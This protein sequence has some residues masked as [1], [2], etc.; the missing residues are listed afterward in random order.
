[1]SRHYT[2]AE[3]AQKAALIREHFDSCALTTDVI[4]GFPGE[5]DEEFEESLSFVKR[6]AFSH[7]HVFKYS[8]RE[9]TLA[10]RMPDQ[11]PENIKNIRS[12]RMIEEMEA[13][14]YEF[15]N[16]FIGKDVSILAEEQTVTKDGKKVWLGYTPEYIKSAVETDEDI[17]NNIVCARV[18]GFT[19][20]ENG[21]IML[22]GLGYLY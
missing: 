16:S 6:M 4:V 3:F 11:V 8:K 21:R 9:G 19:E 5:T 12:S 22:A 20:T 14:R 2:S 10:S 1:M 15:E 13:V 7:T 17:L 18:K